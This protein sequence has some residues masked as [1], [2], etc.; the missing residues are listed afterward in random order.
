MA[1]PFVTAYTTF[2]RKASSKQRHLRGKRGKGMGL[3]RHISAAYQLRKVPCIR[4]CRGS[5]HATWPRDSEPF[6]LLIIRAHLRNPEGN[7][8]YGKFLIKLSLSFS[9]VLSLSLRN[10]AAVKVIMIIMI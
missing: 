8:R 4:S 10:G 5:S 6:L 2:W 3:G 9:Q 7:A 1:I